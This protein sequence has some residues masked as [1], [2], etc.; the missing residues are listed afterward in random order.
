MANDD[1]ANRKNIFPSNIHFLIH[2]NY[3]HNYMHYLV[4]SLVLRSSDPNITR[5]SHISLPKK[6]HLSAYA[7]SKIGAKERGV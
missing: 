2:I 7:A 6:H 4:F 1:F 3:A 5:Y